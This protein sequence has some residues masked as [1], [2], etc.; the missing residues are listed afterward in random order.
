[1][2]EREQAFDDEETIDVYVIYEDPGHVKA[3]VEGMTTLAPA[4]LRGVPETAQL[5]IAGSISIRILVRALI[6]WRQELRAKETLIVDWESGPESPDIYVVKTEN[7]QYLVLRDHNGT[8][9]H[10]L[11]DRPDEIAAA[12]SALKG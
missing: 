11:Y 3:I 4:R 7:P 5:L 1:M 2:G 8:D 10:K 12:I 6:E 9:L